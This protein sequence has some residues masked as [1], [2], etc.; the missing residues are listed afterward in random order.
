MIRILH[1]SDWHLGRTLYN[2]KR[3]EEFEEFLNWLLQVID[4]QH[5]DAL[6][7]SGDIFDN[8]TPSH[9]AQALYY[10][11]LVQVAN[12]GRRHVVVIAGNHDSPTFLEAPKE[13]L[14]FVN[15][16]VV[17]AIHS[18]LSDEIIVLRDAGQQPEAIVCAVPYL[19]DR[20]IRT[21]TAGETQTDKT[22]RLTEGIRNHYAA[23]TQRAEEIR[24]EIATASGRQVPVI[25]MGHLFATGGKTQDGDGVRDL[26]VGSLAGVGGDTFSDTIDYTALGH[27]HVPQLV[28]GMEHIRYSGSPLPMGFGEAKQE[29]L[30]IVA[31]FNERNLTLHPHQV[32]RFQILEQVSGSSDQ[33]ISQLKTLREQ[34]TS[35]WLEINLTGEWSQNNLREQIDELLQD[36]DLQVLCVKNQQQRERML[37]SQG[38][39]ENLADLTPKD[40]FH[41]C[42]KTYQIPEEEWPELQQTHDE[43]LQ[44]L[45]EDDTNAE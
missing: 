12:S 21:V 18:K 41:R 11:F 8:T 43:V 3:Y 42:L 44:S 38:D 26:Y 14:R 25:A 24:T 39:A 5:I 36:T 30:V 35:A 20:D 2:Q 16:H 37:Q 28:G 6:L 17:G 1:T 9:R 32:P 31:E 15:V 23:V 10:R 22:A 19:R 7:V 34:Q 4:E 29:K 45:Y 27:L 13:I 40:V 33:I